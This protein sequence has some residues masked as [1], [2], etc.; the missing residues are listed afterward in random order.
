M[1]RLSKTDAELALIVGHELGHA[2]LEHLKKQ[3]INGYIGE[4]GGAM[5]D[6]G[7]LLGGIYTGGAFS[8]YLQRAGMMAFSVGFE[9]EADYVGAYYAARAGYDIAGA[10]QVWRAMSLESPVVIR[11][12][13]TH[14]T[15]PVRYLQMR[16][17]AEEIAGKQRNNLPLV[18]DMKVA[19]VT[20]EPPPPRDDIP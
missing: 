11:K 5:V 13:T 9:R 8:N 6:G 17:V 18:P 7:F 20:A 15:S 12:A 2:N 1:L 3:E 16:K 4:F 10:E 19:A 14:P